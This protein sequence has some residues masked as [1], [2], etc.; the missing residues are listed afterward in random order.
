LSIKV[1]DVTTIDGN[2]IVTDK[3]GPQASCNP[4]VTPVS[5]GDGGP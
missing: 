4:N 5:G 2:L 3:V 1:T